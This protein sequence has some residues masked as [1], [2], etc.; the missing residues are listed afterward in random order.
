MKQFDE[1]NNLFTDQ[2]NKQGKSDALSDTILKAFIK[3]QDVTER[4]EEYLQ[5]ELFARDAKIRELRE[6][7]KRTETALEST[8][9][10][11]PSID[12]GLVRKS[13][14][15]VN[16]NLLEVMKMGKGYGMFKNLTIECEKEYMIKEMKTINISN[17]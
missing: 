7:L 15:R 9:F 16:I 2:L 10:F 14:K 6:D 11:Y 13:L 8:N 1:V 17:Y 12:I 5:M 4:R 3:S